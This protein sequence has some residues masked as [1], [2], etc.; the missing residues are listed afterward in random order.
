MHIVDPTHRHQLRIMQGTEVIQDALEWVAVDFEGER[1][2][3]YEPKGLLHGHVEVRLERHGTHAR[4]TGDIE[5]RQL[6][7]IAHSLQ[8]APRELPPLIDR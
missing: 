6:L 2:L 4:L 1:F 5:R 3:V 7:E 8:P